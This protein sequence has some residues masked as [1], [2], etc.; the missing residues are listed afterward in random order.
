MGYKEDKEVCKKILRKLTVANEDQIK[1]HIMNVQGETRRELGIKLSKNKLLHQVTDEILRSVLGAEEVEHAR[2]T[3]LA[4][5]G[6]FSAISVLD[7]DQIAL[8]TAK[9]DTYDW[10]KQAD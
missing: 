9:V 3:H 4:L 6:D 10:R 8:I 1:R 2:L 5:E 7:D